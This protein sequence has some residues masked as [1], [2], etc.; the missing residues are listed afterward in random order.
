MPDRN[1]HYSHLKMTKYNR[2]K[3]LLNRFNK[4]MK[5]PSNKTCN[6]LND[7][8]VNCKTPIFSFHARIR[9]QQRS[10]SEDQVKMILVWGRE[11]KQHKGRRVY[12]VGDRESEK[13]QGNGVDLDPLTGAAVVIGNDGVVITVVRTG[14]ISR[15][16]KRFQR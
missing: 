8:C 9:Q 5:R 11:I 16:K 10:I 14:N 7:W 13:E 2:R 3:R 6:L 12:F 4:K 15:L 1:N